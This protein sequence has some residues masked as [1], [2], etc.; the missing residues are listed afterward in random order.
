MIRSCQTGPLD[1]PAG[2]DVFE[3]G[4]GLS[5][6]VVSNGASKILGLRPLPYQLSARGA[7]PRRSRILCD[8][9]EVHWGDARRRCCQNFPGIQPACSKDWVHQV[10]EPC[11]LARPERDYP[12]QAWGVMQ[13]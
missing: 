1:G 6:L 12:G 8:L 7:M 2:A 11:C 5:K 10:G 13:C 9:N 3:L 4:P